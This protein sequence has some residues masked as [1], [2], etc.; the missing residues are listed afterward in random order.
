MLARRKHTIHGIPI[1]LVFASLLRAIGQLPDTGFSQNVKL[2]P[3]SCLSPPK[4]LGPRPG[5]T[6]TPSRLP[7]LQ[8]QRQ[9]NCMAFPITEK[10]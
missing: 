5:A 7:E 2:I 10:S 4:D 9:P 1:T 6:P 3:G 8:C